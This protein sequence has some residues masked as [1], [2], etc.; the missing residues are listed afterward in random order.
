D[1]EDGARALV[2]AAHKPARG[3]H[4]VREK[5]LF[6]RF[7]GGADL[8]I[9]F[10][11]DDEARH[12]RSVQFNSPSTIARWR[13][14]HIRHDGVGD[15]DVKRCARLWIEHAYFSQHIE[16]IGLIDTA[17]FLERRE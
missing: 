2:K 5:R 10:I 8:G 11:V 15:R 13:H 7:Y 6:L 14:Q 17:Q 9:I 3:L 1:L 4:A 16:N 12:G